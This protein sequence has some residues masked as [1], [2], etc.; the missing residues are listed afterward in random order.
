MIASLR[1]PS[2]LH[3]CL[4][5]AAFSSRGSQLTSQRARGRGSSGPTYLPVLLWVSAPQSTSSALQG[6]MPLS[7]PSGVIAPCLLPS[8]PM[9][10]AAAQPLI[11]EVFWLW[12]VRGLSLIPPQPPSPRGHTAEHLIS[13][14]PTCTISALSILLTPSPSSLLLAPAAAHPH[15][16]L[17]A[18]WLSRHHHPFLLQ[19]IKPPFPLASTWP[20]FN[21]P[22]YFW[23]WFWGERDPPL[24]TAW[25][26]APKF[27]ADRGRQLPRVNEWG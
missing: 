23:C 13:T 9:S 21:S 2:A 15:Q 26:S 27:L 12:S 14:H 19:L 25:S 5:Q 8:V 1:V 11:V 18:L 4:S 22:V 24:F 3:I 6:S 10:L 17:W 16:D 20:S 7:P